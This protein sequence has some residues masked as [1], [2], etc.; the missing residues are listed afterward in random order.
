MFDLSMLD[1]AEV[2]PA[3]QMDRMFEGGFGTVFARIGVEAAT[4]RKWI[5]ATKVPIRELL[6]IYSIGGNYV[7]QRL[8]FAFTLAR[9]N[10]LEEAEAELGRYSKLPELRGSGRSRLIRLMREQT[11]GSA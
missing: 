10:R 7:Q 9:G 2:V 6:T 3:K 4:S 5:R 1:H 8:T 11:R